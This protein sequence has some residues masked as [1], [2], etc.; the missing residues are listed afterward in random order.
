MIRKWLQYPLFFLLIPVFFVFHGFV[1]NCYYI[2]FTDCWLLFGIYTGAAIVVYL[3]GWLLLKSRFKAA[4]FSSFVMSFYLFFGALHDFLRKNSIFLHKYS[5]LLPAFLVM[6]VLLI[7]Y[8]RKKSSFLRVTLFLN[9]LLII[10]MVV[11]GGILTWK[12][13]F[14][15][16]KTSPDQSLAYLPVIRCDTCSKPD[17]YFIIFDDYSGSSTLK[18]VYHYDNSSFDRF[19]EEEGFHIQKRSRSNYAATPLSIASMLN[20]AYLS[21]LDSSHFLASE[22]YT[23]LAESIAKN[24]VAG[25]LLSQGYSIVNYSIFDLPGHP[26]TRYQTFFPVK[27][28]LISHRT[29]LGY[30]ERDLREGLENDFED[31]IFL[32]GKRTV[33]FDRTNRLFLAQT[34][35][36]S[37]KKSDHP[38]FIYTHLIMP[39]FPFFYDSLMHRRPLRDIASREDEDPEYYLQYLPYTNSCAMD[40]IST[41]KRNT[42]GNA[43]I[44]FMS[45]HGFRYIPNGKDLPG[46][47]FNNQNAV[48]FPDGD[49]HLFYDSISAVNQFRVIFNKMFRQNLPLLKDSSIFLIT[50]E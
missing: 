42:G 34:K 43:V 11:D 15:D 4:L 29:L 33:E 7:L 25:F 17:I 39:H 45:D 13:L 8:L 10:Y 23:D 12:L 48:Y 16:R 32:S 30:I 3:L 6:T 40:L 20:F 18:D 49:Y 37:Q 21:N 44:I 2:R 46:Y 50:K 28:E 19:L 1:E 26:S 36:E 14:K 27:T 9:S 31:S 35:E 5:I 24:R 47:A 38:R 22:D 41:I